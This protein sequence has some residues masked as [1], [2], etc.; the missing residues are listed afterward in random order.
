MDLSALR[1]GLCW[2]GVALL[3]GC[4]PT[5]SRQ[6][7]LPPELSRAQLFDCTEQ[8][9]T[10]LRAGRTAWEPVSLRD[11]VAGVLESGHYG[12][13]NRIGLRIRLQHHRGSDRAQ[14]WVRGAG[15][16]FTDLGVEAAAGQLQNA[17]Q[18]CLR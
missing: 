2:L 1:P 8:A 12:Q 5:G 11:D 13:H 14:L 6:L 3:V 7:A 16:Y 4:V 9:L 15:P 10:G 17:L 18:Q